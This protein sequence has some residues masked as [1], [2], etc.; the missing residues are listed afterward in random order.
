ARFA[1]EYNATFGKTSDFAPRIARVREACERIGR[2]PASLILSM[3]GTV[4]VG[5]NP[6]EAQRRAAI[7]GRPLEAIADGGFAGAPGD[8]VDRVGYLRDLG[9]TRVYFQV[10]DIHDLDQVELL[11]SE[12]VSHFS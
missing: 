3:P 9:I 10:L 11:A 7:V 1:A 5:S 6:A 4:A 12:V 2:D 8:V